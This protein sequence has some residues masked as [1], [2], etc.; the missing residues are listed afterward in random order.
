MEKQKSPREIFWVGVGFEPERLQNG[1]GDAHGAITRYV[2]HLVGTQD[3]AS[4]R[5]SFPNGASIHSIGSEIGEL[6]DVFRAPDGARIGFGKL[7]D[8]AHEG[9]EYFDQMRWW[10]AK[11]VNVHMPVSIYVWSPATPRPTMLV[12]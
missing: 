10:M 9:K 8:D 12:P 1:V 2:T 7:V 5:E 4:R 6:V 11:E 3:M